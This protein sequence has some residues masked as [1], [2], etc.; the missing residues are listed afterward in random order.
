MT[1]SLD[2]LALASA[3]VL[4]ATVTTA[5]FGNVQGGSQPLNGWFG[6][7]PVLMTLAFG[8]LMPL[9]SIM[10]KVDRQL[11][12]LDSK[13]DRR[14]AHRAFMSLA[15][16][17]MLLGY[18]CIFQ[19]HRPV[20]KYLGYDFVKH[21][22]APWQR[23]VHIYC[24][25]A[26]MTL[27]LYQAVTGMLKIRNLSLHGTGSYKNHGKIGEFVLTLGLVAILMAISFWM[28]STT[29]KLLIAL[30]AILS[31]FIGRFKSYPK[32]G[33]S[34]PIVQESA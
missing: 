23:L 17:F 31:V 5:I 14:N 19:A 7:H 27:A 11:T 33:E 29:L 26:A 3:V 24:G 28:W 2:L 21:E 25:Y 18:L 10:Q 32:T 8:C 12:H 34:R 4:V 1:K 6:W 20:H 9:G 22:W 16:F 13:E 30:L 15:V